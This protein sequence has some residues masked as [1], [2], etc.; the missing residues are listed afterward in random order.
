MSESN[1]SLSHTV[2]QI[3]KTV[4]TITRVISAFTQVTKEKSN[5][6]SFISRH[7][8]SIDIKC[9]KIVAKNLGLGETRFEA[10]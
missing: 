5:R 3:I 6:Q 2:L 7:I 4:H 8:L 10:I 1:K 9:F